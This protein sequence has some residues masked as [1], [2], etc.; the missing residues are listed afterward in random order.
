[1]GKFEDLINGDK[2]VLIDF[3]AT[4]CGPCQ[5]MNP[6]IKDVAKKLKDKATV[7]KIDIDKNEALANKLN[8]RGVPTFIIYKKG[9]IMWRN[10]GMQS[11]TNLINQVLELA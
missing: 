9:E 10:S 3:H 2:P 1:M 8:I 4:W 5:S 6:I 11:G 7:I